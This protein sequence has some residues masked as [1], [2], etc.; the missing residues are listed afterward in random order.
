MKTL[1][2][3][4]PVKLCARCDEGQTAV[5]GFEGSRGMR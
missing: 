3:V 2:T 4:R 1:K 5:E